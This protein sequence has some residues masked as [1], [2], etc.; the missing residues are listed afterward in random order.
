M[1]SATTG[2][3]TMS[4]DED[5]V[6]AVEAGRLTG[7]SERTI[8]RQ[9]AAH[10]LPARHVA[11]NRYAILV[12]DLRLSRP[13]G[14]TVHQL[15]ARL[16]ALEDRVGAL[17]QQLTRLLASP[18]DAS[19]ADATTGPS[20][21]LT[22]IGASFARLASELSHLTAALADAPGPASHLGKAQP[23]ADP[24]PIAERAE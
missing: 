22:E 13:G 6:S 14:T 18:S 24:Q 8:R 23:R 10:R 2:G 5:E 19:S 20:S 16:Q 11:C 3:E 4:A 7:L 17:E 9:I 15:T 1:K 12:R 21:T